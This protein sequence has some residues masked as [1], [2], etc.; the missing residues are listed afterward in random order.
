M[1]SPRGNAA[2]IAQNCYARNEFS[3]TFKVAFLWIVQP[4]GHCNYHD[5]SNAPLRARHD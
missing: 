2:L 1:K 3:G 5:A 4:L